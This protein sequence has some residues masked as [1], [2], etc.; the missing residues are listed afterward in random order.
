MP[1]YEFTNQ[2]RELLNDALATLIFESDGW[3]LGGHAPTRM[4]DVATSVRDLCRLRYKIFPEEGITN[5]I[6]RLN[7]PA[8]PTLPPEPVHTF[9]VY[10]GGKRCYLDTDSQKSKYG[11]R[12]TFWGSI[13]SRKRHPS[14]M[15][16]KTWVPKDKVW[17]PDWEFA[18]HEFLDDALVAEHKITH[19]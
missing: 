10:S 18:I 13:N 12:D 11:G 1:F 9:S 15:S 6:E 16:A 5:A 7:T 4:P 3:Q 19:G 14:L 17:D 2:E 8:R